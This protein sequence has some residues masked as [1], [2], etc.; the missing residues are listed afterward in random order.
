MLYLISKAS[1]I[2]IDGVYMLDITPELDGT[3]TGG[4][5]FGVSRLA[6]VKGVQ[7]VDSISVVIE[8]L[9]TADI[10]VCRL[11]ISDIPKSLVTRKETISPTLKS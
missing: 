7:L 1:S 4:V 5:V 9:V 10:R 6:S 11:F 3:Q 2:F 8:S